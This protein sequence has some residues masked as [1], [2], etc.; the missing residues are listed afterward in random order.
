MQSK[1]HPI[2]LA[3]RV[4][5]VYAWT[6]TFPPG[7]TVSVRHSYAPFLGSGIT[8]S[9][10]PDDRGFSAKALRDEFCASPGLYTGLNAQR[11]AMRRHSGE[12]R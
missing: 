11:R 8:Q 3:W 12:A 1:S 6:L 4:R 10:I 9:W 5:I 7:K 2:A